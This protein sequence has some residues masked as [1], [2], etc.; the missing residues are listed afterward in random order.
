[1]GFNSG[2]KGL[3]AGRKSHVGHVAWM[4]DTKHHLSWCQPG[5]GGT[6]EVLYWIPIAQLKN[7]RGCR[8]ISIYFA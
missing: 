8:F 7:L 1:M 6:V 5:R 2:F 4:E 3:T